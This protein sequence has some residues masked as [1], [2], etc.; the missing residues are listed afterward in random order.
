MQP[1]KWALNLRNF[2]Q[3]LDDAH[4]QTVP[5]VHQVQ[6][7]LLS[8]S[9]GAD[10]SLHRRW[11]HQEGAFF[12]HGAFF[13]P[14]K[15]IFFPQHIFYSVVLNEDDS[16]EKNRLSKLHYRFRQYTSL[17]QLQ[18]FWLKLNQC[19]QSSEGVLDAMKPN[20][21]EDHITLQAS[22]F[23]LNSRTCLSSKSIMQLTETSFSNSVIFIEK[24]SIENRIWAKTN[25]YGQTNFFS[26]SPPRLPPRQP[27]QYPGDG[28]SRG[29]TSP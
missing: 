16:I 25:F 24:Q 2:I 26:W 7:S 23:E 6:E 1:E 19:L 29:S 3:V 10:A 28:S 18:L 4:K 17:I 13:L 11:G 14:T 12:F 15:I 21:E 20:F 9:I 8:E 5:W 27:P 22:R